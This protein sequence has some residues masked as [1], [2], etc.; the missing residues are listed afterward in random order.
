M[1]T[2]RGY[3]CW[4][5][6]RARPRQGVCGLTFA[7]TDQRA[8]RL[9]RQYGLRTRPIAEGNTPS[10]ICGRFKVHCRADAYAGFNQLCKALGWIPQEI[11]LYP[12]LTCRENL[13]S[14]GRYHELGG[15]TLAQA[16]K[17]CLDWS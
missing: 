4:R 3:R 11:A 12:R 14:F 6:A 5:R 2:T 8:I 16:I 10:N 7:T 9:L 1:R 15:A 13:Q 17:R